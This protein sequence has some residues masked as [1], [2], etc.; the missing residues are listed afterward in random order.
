GAARS[1]AGSAARLGNRGNSPARRP[2]AGRRARRAGRLALLPPDRREPGLPR[3]WQALRTM[4][5][6]QKIE[7]GRTDQRD[8]RLIPVK[9][10]K[11]AFGAPFLVVSA[12]IRA[13]QHAG[14]TQTAA[15]GR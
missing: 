1:P 9:H 2:R 5:L 6:L 12:R 11:T 7:S 14:R 15:Q 3:A 4:I 10:A 8:P 13:K